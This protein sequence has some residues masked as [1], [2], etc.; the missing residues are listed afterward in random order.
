VVYQT[1]NQIKTALGINNWRNLLHDKMMRFTSMMPAMNPTVMMD[2]ISQLPQFWHF[3]QDVLK[4]LESR[5]EIR[6]NPVQAGLLKEVRRFLDRDLDANQ[7][8][9]PGKNK[10]LDAV[11]AAGNLCYPA[12]WLGESDLQFL[13]VIQNEPICSQRTV[14]IAALTFLGGR[15]PA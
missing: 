9:H 12:N 8:R 14:L 7:P 4:T 3:S 11:L 10:Y 2:L 5:P 15:L 1:D 13:S 6:Q